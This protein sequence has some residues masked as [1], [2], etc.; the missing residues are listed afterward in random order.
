MIEHDG[1]P[2]T[3]RDPATL[4]DVIRENGDQVWQGIDTVPGDDARG[5]R[6]YRPDLIR[7]HDRHLNQRT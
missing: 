7:N 4:A 2:M 5:D 3:G 1:H 6:H